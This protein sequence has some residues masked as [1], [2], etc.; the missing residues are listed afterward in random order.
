MKSLDGYMLFKLTLFIMGFELYL[1]KH[2]FSIPT[3]EPVFDKIKAAALNLATAATAIF[4]FSPGR[5]FSRRLG[6]ASQ[7]WRVKVNMGNFVLKSMKIGMT[8]NSA[9]YKRWP[10]CPYDGAKFLSKR[11]KVG[12]QSNGN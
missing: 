12:R 7:R 6:S 3:L 5:N 4:G 11:L 10:P 9:N 8:L 1:D 2:G